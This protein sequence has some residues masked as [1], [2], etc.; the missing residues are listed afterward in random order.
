MLLGFH[1]PKPPVS[2]FPVCI[3]PPPSPPLTQSPLPLSVFG[4][5]TAETRPEHPPLP[6]LQFWKSGIKRPQLASAAA[7][8]I[9]P[10][11]WMPAP[12]LSRPGI[13]E[14]DVRCPPELDAKLRSKRTA[15][16]SQAGHSGR[17]LCA[18]LLQLPLSPTHLLCRLPYRCRCRCCWWWQTCCWF[19]SLCWSDGQHWAPGKEEGEEYSLPYSSATITADFFFLDAHVPAYSF[20]E[21]TV[22]SLFRCQVGKC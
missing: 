14:R 21:C 20:W 12:F 7:F 16:W 18:L 4:N 1:L 5:V 19:H 22:R 8:P 10:N 11:A 17:M 9:F 2:R 15:P 13:R 6:H 3:S